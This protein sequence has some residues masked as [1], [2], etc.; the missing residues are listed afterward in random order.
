M[1]LIRRVTSV[2]AIMV[3]ALF[4]VAQ[5]SCAVF[6]SLWD[7]GPTAEEYEQ[8]AEETRIEA[9]RFAASGDLD[10][11]VDAMDT[12]ADLMGAAAEAKKGDIGG[13]VD[14]VVNF[15]PPPYNTLATSVAGLAALWWGRGHQKMGK[16]V[17]RS[18][19]G[20]AA[21]TDA[22]R[23]SL[24]KNTTHRSR[25]IISKTKSKDRKKAAKIAV[26]EAE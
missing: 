9:D 23:E 5:P 24:S 20:D 10:G 18:F 8:M 16:Q 2:S 13:V 1:N 6:Q 7:N 17:V 25:S 4:L 22:Q 3:L 19:K 21:L 26:D 14:L 11:A 12:V 15:I